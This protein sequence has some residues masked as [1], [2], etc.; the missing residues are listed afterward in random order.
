MRRHEIHSGGSFKESQSANKL[1]SLRQLL[2]MEHVFPQNSIIN[3]SKKCTK[4]AP[5]L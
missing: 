3:K 1:L 5:I 2:D 4:T